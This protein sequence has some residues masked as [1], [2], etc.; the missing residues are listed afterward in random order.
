MKLQLVSRNVFRFL[1]KEKAL[2]DFC[3][4]RP[5]IGNILPGFE[6]MLSLMHVEVIN[7]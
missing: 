4:H 1:E 5:F 2:A 7:F 3:N 6:S